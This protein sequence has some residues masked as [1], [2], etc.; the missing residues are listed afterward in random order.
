MWTIARGQ[1]DKPF[2]KIGQKVHTG[3]FYYPF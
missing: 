2:Y 3:E 1:K